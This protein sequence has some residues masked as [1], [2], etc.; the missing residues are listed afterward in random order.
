MSA[1]TA[2]A[3]ADEAATPR[4]QPLPLP[5]ATPGSEEVTTLETRLKTLKGKL[6]VTEATS[7]HVGDPQHAGGNWDSKRLGFDTP[8]SLVA[9]LQSSTFEI[10]GR[11]RHQSVGVPSGRRGRAARGVAA[12]P[13]RHDCAPGR[14]V[15]RE[16]RAKLDAPGLSLGWRELRASDLAGRARAF[17]SMVG[18]GMAIEEAARLAGLM[19]PDE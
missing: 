19:E 15:E 5:G 2:A 18:G 14:A 7:T 17:Q 4:G 12:N 11:L 6:L 3:L 1:G 16:L 8:H 9:L 10:H 13:V